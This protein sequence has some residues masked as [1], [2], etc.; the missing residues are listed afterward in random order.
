MMTAIA[1]APRIEEHFFA[2][3]GLVPNNAALPV[4][5]YRGAL[6]TGAGAAS[7]CEALFAGNGWPNA[8][9]DGV[10]AHHH[11][12][13]TAH[14][15]LGVVAGSARVRLG[16][17]NGE[18]VDI[19]AGD[20]VVIPAGVAHK[21]EGASPDLLIVGAYPRGQ[22]PDMCAPGERERQRAAGNIAAVPLPKRDP[23][24]GDRGPLP[25]RWIRP[26][27]G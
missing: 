14:E 23:V 27:Q 19:H 20:V 12:H 24:G 16:G 6:A 10:Y 1:D 25:G 4:L 22:H 13:S 17:A 18:L 26:R 9:R 2:D 8:W 11:Y 15:A 21:N 7:A 5:V 3:D